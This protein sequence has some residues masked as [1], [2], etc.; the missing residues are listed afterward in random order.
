MEPHSTE[1]V[2]KFTAMGSGGL[3]VI[4]H[5]TL[6]KLKWSVSSWD[7]Q[8]QHGREHILGKGLVVSGKCTGTAVGMNPVCKVA[9]PVMHIAATEMMPQ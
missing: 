5:G 9:V 2:L 4:T 7:M 8:Y 1:V 3:C 6:T